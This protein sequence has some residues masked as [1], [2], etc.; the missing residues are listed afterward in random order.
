MNLI[1]L[2]MLSF[3]FTFGCAMPS[4]SKVVF[5]VSPDGRDDG[6]GT[7]DRP[8]ATIQRARVAIRSQI[9]AG[10]NRNICV[11]IR[12]G[13]YYL[14][15][16][17]T[18]GPEDSGTVEHSITYTAYPGEKAHLIGG[19]P[20]TGWKVYKGDIQVA[21][22]PDDTKPSQL[23]AN[24]Q[25]LTMARIP[26]NDYFT[27]QEGIGPNGTAF[28]YKSEDI[29]PASWDWSGGSVFIWAGENWHSQDRLIEDLNAADRTI[30]LSGPINYK[31]YKIKAGNRY[32]VKNILALLT[33]ARECRIDQS[34]GLL[35]AWTEGGPADKQKMIIS[36]S[37]YVLGI[38]G[39]KD[40]IVRN[41]HFKDLDVDISN[42]HTIFLSNAEDCSV[43]FC[44]VANAAL[45]G[46][47]INEHAQRITIYGNLIEQ[48]GD[49]G[50]EINGTDQPLL[51]HHDWLE[52][53]VFAPDEKGL[54]NLTQPDWNHH[55]VVE[56]NHIR[57]CGRLVGHGCGVMMFQSGSNCVIHNDI[58]HM[59]RWGASIKGIVLGYLAMRVP[60]V[61]FEN[62]FQYNHANN[63]LIAYNNI[64]HVNQDS[65]DTGGI[66]SWGPGRDNVIDHNIIHDTGNERFNL[67][68]GIYLDDATNFFTVTN[69]IIYNVMGTDM[70]QCIFAKGRGNVIR[71]NILIVN[72]ANQAAFTLMTRKDSE[73]ICD[74]TYTHNI[75]SI[76]PGLGSLY[77]FFLYF[78]K[79]LIKS[80]DYNLIW[81][82]DQPINIGGDCPAKTFE[83][84]RTLPDNGYD[85][86]SLVADPKFVDPANHN[87]RLNPDSPA[88][89][90]GFVD[91][92]TSKIGLKDDYPADRLDAPSAKDNPPLCFVL[93]RME[94]VNPPDEAGNGCRILLYMEN[95]GK[96]RCAGRIG[97]HTD[98]GP[99]TTA[100]G[101]NMM[102]YDLKPGQSAK[103]IFSIIA[104]KA[105]DTTVEITSSNPDVQRTSM[106]IEAIRWKVIKTDPIAS[107]ENIPPALASVSPRYALNK[108]HAGLLRIAIAGNEL[109]VH[110]K[111][112]DRD[113]LIG[114][115]GWENRGLD[116]MVLPMGGNKVRGVKFH[117]T[118]WTTGESFLTVDGKVDQV[119]PPGVRFMVRPLFNG[120]YELMG[121]IPLSLLQIDEHIN[122]F[123][124]DGFL[125]LAVETSS[126]PIKIPLF[127][128]TIDDRQLGEKSSGFVIVMPR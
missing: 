31:H 105:A 34:K 75:V 117:P 67:Q 121:L 73:N 77:H 90:L 89:K 91:I 103:K 6:P 23:F 100:D 22:I 78:N 26:K 12:G 21:R 32:I 127:N 111:I 11:V 106:N 28:R 18:F 119:N 17:I 60:G 54:K 10:L 41:I 66:E 81:K 52:T 114:M 70:N 112:M 19:L 50:V 58:H 40:R 110:A 116:I 120:G 104:D 1:F 74:H 20:I 44:R 125:S 115:P 57:Y 29:N 39:T 56:N 108:N 16:G 13:T 113:I 71:N 8:F 36:T 85:T 99:G 102:Q 123:R 101:G 69:N 72:A 35:Y 47:Y 63:N 76:Q 62:Q 37:P 25:R 55:N 107:L 24:G 87:Y 3:I 83:A 43:K 5:A 4:S 7:L 97:V 128:L 86:N 84:W 65:Q 33:Q 124:M 109:A 61:T 59:P 88:I 53:I 95:I 94:L 80:S 122:Q 30:T 48:N 93:T 118:G 9:A 46:L 45:T 38:V 14:P 49:N 126:S 27:V 2:C 51:D 79:E 68:S 42:A 92:D 64:H 98:K 15:E 96:V 82:G